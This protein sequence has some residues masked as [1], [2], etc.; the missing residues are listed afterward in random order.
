MRKLFLAAPIA[1]VA[2]GVHL[3]LSSAG[4]PKIGPDKKTWDTVAQN[5]AKFL[6]STQDKNGGWSTDKTPRRHRRRPDRPARSRPGHAAGPGRREGASSTSRAWSTRKEAHRRQGRRRSS[7]RTTSPA[8]TS[9][10]WPRPSRT[11]STRRSSATPSSSSRSSSG[12]RAKARPERRLLRRRRLR[13]QIAARPVQHA[14]LP[15]RPQGR[16]RRRRTTRPCKKALVFVSRC[17]NLKGETQRPAL[18]RQ[19]QRRQLHL[20]RRRPAASPRSSTSRCAD[21]SLPGY[22]SMTYAG[23][24][25]MIY[26]G[27]SKDDPRVKK[28][29]EWI[30]QQLHGGQE[31]RHARSARAVGPVLLLPHDGQDASTRWASITSST[32]RASS[33][34]GARTSPRRWPSGSGPTAAG[35]RR[36]QLDGSRP[37][38]GHRL[39]ADGAELLP[40][41]VTIQRAEPR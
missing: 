31:P 11:T 27:V 18:G 24:K 7:C 37:E 6:Q 12:T 5:A 35:Q 9:W 41:E 29:Y 33:T 38:P 14:V 13:Q 19:D 3:G 2:L 32:P 30:Q 10:P 21:G 39:R 25:S 17:Q 4:Q 40:A 8:S 36:R 1:L 22:G 15:R 20:H 34:T 16:R 23:I 28:A 26:C